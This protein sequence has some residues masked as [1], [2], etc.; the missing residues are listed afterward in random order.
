[1]SR[2][3]PHPLASSIL[4]VA[5]LVIVPR[6]TVAH[7]LLAAVLAVAIPLFTQ[8]LAEQPVR[9]HRPGAILRLTLVVLW[10]IVVANLSVAR[11]VL[12]PVGRLRPRFIVVPLDATHP[13]AV[14]LLASIVTMT[15]GTVSCDV[16]TEEQQ[17]LV[18]ALDVDDP[19]ELVRQIKARY[20]RPLKEIF[21]C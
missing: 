19:D 20:E 10:D 8:R 15:P 16:R 6:V 9:V 1:M 17:I 13:N 5:W 12:G 11:L 14:A 18:H 2:W 7:A 21:G 3:L 4:A